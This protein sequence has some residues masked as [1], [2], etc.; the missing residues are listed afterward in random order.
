MPANFQKYFLG[1]IK[2]TDKDKS[3]HRKLHCMSAIQG[4]RDKYEISKK[5]QI[6]LNKIVNFIPP[7]RISAGVWPAPRIGMSGDQS[8]G[9]LWL[10][11][12]TFPAVVTPWSTLRRIRSNQFSNPQ[13]WSNLNNDLYFTFITLS[14]NKFLIN[15]FTKLTFWYFEISFGRKPFIS[16]CSHGP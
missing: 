8:V 14:I 5:K 1:R 16:S 4:Q 9:F 6:M 11:T 10:I 2:Y 15:P 12:L 7:L 3:K 13:E